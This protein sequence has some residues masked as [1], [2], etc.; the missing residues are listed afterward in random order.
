MPYIFFIKLFKYT[1]I[2]T[3]SLLLTDDYKFFLG[4]TLEMLY[5]SGAKDSAYDRFIGKSSFF[6]QV[7]E[8]EVLFTNIFC[9]SNIDWFYKWFSSANRITSELSILFLDVLI[10]IYLLMDAMEFLKTANPFQ[11]QGL[12][13]CALWNMWSCRSVN[14]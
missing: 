14:V 5:Y 10:I 2:L 3:C 9:Y 11:E 6:L 4:L 1:V 8:W 13:V 12:P 7:H